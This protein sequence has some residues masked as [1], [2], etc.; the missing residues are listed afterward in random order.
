M[1]MRRPP[2]R[3]TE[4][5]SPH[6]RPK[7]MERKPM[8]EWTKAIIICIASVSSFVTFAW[9]RKSLH[10]QRKSANFEKLDRCDLTSYPIWQIGE[11]QELN[12]SGCDNINLP[13][14]SKLWS[15]FKSLRKLDLNNSTL[16]DLPDEMRFLSSLEI[17]FLSENQFDQ[18]PNVVRSLHNLRVLS[19]RGNSLQELSASDLPISSIVWLILTNN[20][21]SKIHSNI[22]DAKLLRKLMLSHN[23][24][25]DIPKEMGKCKNLELIRLA[26]NN[27]NSLPREILTLP[28]LAWISLSGNP[29]SK[30][31]KNV[32]KIIEETEVQMQSKVLGSGASGVVYKAKHNGK[33]VAVKIFKQKIKGSDGNAADE[34]SINGLINHP[35]AISAIGVIPGESAYKGMVMDLLSGTHPLGKV[36]NFG[37]VT[38]DEGPSPHSENLTME[39]VLS[40]VWNVASVLDYIHS[41]IGVSHS[42]VYLHNV[43]RDEKF[44]SRLSDW[45]ASF[46]YDRENNELSEMFERIE[47]LAFG[48]LIQD[49]F[50]WHFNIVVPDST[51]PTSY[52]GNIKMG[53]AKL[54]KGPLY[55]L[56]SLI[57][58]PDQARRPNFHIIKGMLENIP[59]FSNL[60]KQ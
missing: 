23:K 9:Y 5:G 54:D 44:V 26:T 38:R 4:M 43:L 24:I 12:L 27:I 33:D 36:P 7:E 59:D 29:M 57:L 50:Q 55:D 48:R 53:K 3:R 10:L 41:S 51:E 22:G 19:L 21:I 11:L 47:V 20:E 34:A 32:E 28:K 35:L 45:G 14:D 49:L 60:P 25:T 8:F 13:P 56:I 58:Q 46:V 16:K 52:L 37:T 6:L 39:Q 2:V 18:I 42:D 15:R 30:S 40:V 31:P 1:R 17:L